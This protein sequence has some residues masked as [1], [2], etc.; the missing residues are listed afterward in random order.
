MIVYI[1][2][3]V[4]FLSL[5]KKV[6]KEVSLRRRC[7]PVLPHGKPPSLRIHPA[8]TISLPSTLTTE[9]IKR[10]ALLLAAAGAL[11]ALPICIALA[12]WAEIGTFL[13]KSGSKLRCDQLPAMRAE[14]F[15]R[16]RLQLRE[17]LTQRPFGLLLLVLFL[18]EQEKYRENDSK[19]N[20]HLSFLINL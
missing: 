15:Q 14:G 6:T 13:P 11:A 9:E 1:S 3:D 4:T 10:M 5:N 12:I 17:Q 2:K 18:Q 19:V 7:P 16:E 8:R 20:D